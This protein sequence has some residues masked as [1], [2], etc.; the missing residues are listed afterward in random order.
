MAV[1]EVMG[2]RKA[3]RGREVLRSASLR[4]VS[5]ECVGILGVNGAGKSTLLGI[6]AGTLR[7]NG[8]Q[9][10]WEGQDLLRDAKLRRRVVGYVPQGTCLFE[11]LSAKENLRLWYS[12]E[13]MSAELERG[14]LRTLGVDAFLNQRVDALSGGMKKRLAIGC[15]VAR[16][17]P[18]LLLDEPSAALDLQCKSELLAQ[19]RAMREGGVTML[20]STHDL[21]EIALCDRLYLLQDAQLTPVEP[22]TDPAR[23]LEKLG[24]N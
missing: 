14:I 18:L 12:P 9:A 24:W 2:L 8:G 7:P 3:Y 23:L 10:I 5:G 4:A 22:E 16:H 6:L 1:L 15:A 19:L 21:Q 20:L 17:P 11:D 13:Q